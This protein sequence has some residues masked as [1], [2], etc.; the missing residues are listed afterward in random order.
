MI[1][2]YVPGNGFLGTHSFDMYPKTAFWV[3]I[4]R[5]PRAGGFFGE[6]IMKSFVFILLFSVFFAG[7]MASYLDTPVVYQSYSTR[8]VKGWEDR[9]GYHSC[10]DDTPCSIPESYDLVWVK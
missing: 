5:P 4:H 8:A 1:P 2:L 9:S 10:G 3:H 6:V 7:L